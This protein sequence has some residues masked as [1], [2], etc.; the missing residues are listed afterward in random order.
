MTADPKRLVASGYDGITDRYLARYGASAVRDHW[1]AELLKRLPAQGGGRVL[2]LGCGAGIP[3]AAALAA[4]G[5]TV[6][7]VDGSSAQISL[8]RGN[9]PAAK[10]I[11][12]DMTE[13]DL[14]ARSFD[15]VAAFYSITHVPR[16]EHDALLR[17]IAAW[18]KPDGLLVA[19]LGADALSD[20]RGEWLGT[21]M[22]FSHYDAEANLA[23]LRGA[24]FVIDRSEVMAQDNET[25][26]F[27][28]VVARAT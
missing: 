5:H 21:E 18:L 28:W 3:L 23:L 10:F 24:G 27:L 17:R 12:A 14:A 15:V 9:V 4:A 8:A 13:V 26:R 2:D 25:A 16:G 22:F 1:L 20:W 19:S 11:E 7:G 6:V